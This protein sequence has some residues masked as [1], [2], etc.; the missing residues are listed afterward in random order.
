M[1][2]TRRFAG[3]LGRVEP[4]VVALAGGQQ[5][6]GHPGLRGELLPGPT[7]GLLDTET[8]PCIIHIYPQIVNMYLGLL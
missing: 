8:H 2:P 7:G 6:Q 3:G 1:R 4:P 5:L